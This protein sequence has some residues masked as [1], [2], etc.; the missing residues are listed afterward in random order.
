MGLERTVLINEK[1]LLALGDVVSEGKFA[2]DGAALARRSVWKGSKLMD[3]SVTESAKPYQG[4]GNSFAWEAGKSPVSGYQLVRPLGRG[5]MGEVW[6]AA[7]PGGVPVALKRVDLD[8][9][10]GEHELQALELLKR[11]RHPHL[12][13]LNGYWIAGHLLII[14]LELADTDLRSLLNAGRQ[15][16]VQGLTPET[17]TRYLTD[18]AEAL[19]YLA[20]PI[21]RLNSHAVRIQHRDMNATAKGLLRVRN[22]HSSLV[23][24]V[25]LAAGRSER[26]FR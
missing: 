20:R 22:C 7:G 11:V 5:G 3:P 17:I 9:P 10:C 18:A 1:G 24:W 19:D 23:S 6:E 13:A 26:T 25:T 16:S 21:H 4:D 12:L 15:P 14:G 2:R 8:R